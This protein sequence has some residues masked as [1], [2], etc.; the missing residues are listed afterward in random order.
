[1]TLRLPTRLPFSRAELALILA[2]VIWGA[3]FLIVHTAMQ[4][5]G[6]LFFGAACVI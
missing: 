5:S 4:H 1:M 2:T 3:S 6:P